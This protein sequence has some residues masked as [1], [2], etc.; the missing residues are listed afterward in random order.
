MFVLNLFVTSDS[1]AIASGAVLS[2][3]LWMTGWVSCIENCIVQIP[4]E[5]FKANP[6]V[7]VHAT[8]VGEE[9]WKLS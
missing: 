2:H 3:E 8:S 7:Q 6:N 9:E 1:E 4:F 5:C